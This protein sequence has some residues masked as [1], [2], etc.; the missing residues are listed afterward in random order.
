MENS[1]LGIVFIHGA[2]LNGYVWK[3]LTIKL[4]VPSLSIDFPNRLSGDKVNINLS[5][6]DYINSV[7]GQIEQWKHQRLII[8]AHSIGACV[9]LELLKHFKNEVKGFVAV[10]S[11]IP[12]SGNSFISSLP[13]PQNWMLPII[14]KL[15]GTRPPRKMIENELCNDLTPDQ[16][17]KVVNEFTPESKA[18]YSTRINY[19]MP[20]I[21]RLYIKL[22]NDNSV[23]PEIQQ[24]MAYNLQAKIVSVDSGHLP[25]ISRPNELA[26]ILSQ[27]ITETIHEKNLLS[28]I[29]PEP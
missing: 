18:L 11:V 3:D 28:A 14:L 6:D 7:K 24:E 4:N 22:T 29:N 23:K 2:G 5:F 8:V 26:A 10:G 1:N 17:R 16:T 20:E 9:G 12:V 13:F 25:M 21:Y 27:F 19:I 15:M